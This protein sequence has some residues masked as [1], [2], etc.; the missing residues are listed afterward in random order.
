MEMMIRTG[1]GGSTRGLN[2][3]KEEKRSKDLE[4]ISSTVGRNLLG[5]R[6]NAL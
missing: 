1:L 6:V 5:G 3:G 2:I 4:E